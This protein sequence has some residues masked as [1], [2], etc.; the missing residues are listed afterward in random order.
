MKLTTMTVRSASLPAGKSEAIFFDDSVPGFGLRVREGGSRSFVFQYKVGAKQRRIALGSVAAIELGKARDT[1]KTLYARVRLGEDPAGDKAES[2][3]KAAET[4]EATAALYLAYQKGELRPRSY[5][6]VER[7]LLKHAKVL[8]GLQLG[9][10]ERRDIATCIT[11]VAKNSGAVTG[12]RVRTSLS[13]FFAWSIAQGLVEHNP[14][15][16]TTRNEEFS[17]ERV[18]SPDEYRLIWQALGD[19]DFGAI[20]KLLALTGQ[21]AGEVAG[22][23]WSEIALETL[24]KYRWSLPGERTKNHRPHTVPLSEVALAIIAARPRRANADGTPRDLIFGRGDGPFS[25]WSKSREA[26]ETEITKAAGKALPHWMP[27]DLR[28]SF[29]THAAGLGIQPHVIEAVLNHVSGHKA[30]VAG[31]YNRATYEP[32]KRQALDLWAEQLLAWAENRESKV[33]ILPRRA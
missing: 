32:E 9:K 8:H 7:H 5:A 10:I 13:G 1:A 16:G 27:H 30:G 18:L 15:T 11:T 6:D 4:F 24:E 31:I 12:N 28:R 33:T 2:K 14:V 23:R 22:M 19:D 26:L 17:R 29:A 21:R 20:M 3:A 25:G